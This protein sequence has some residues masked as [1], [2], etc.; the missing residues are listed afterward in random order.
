MI[1]IKNSKNMKRCC[2]VIP[3]HESVL[4]NAEKT[5]VNSIMKELEGYHVVFVGP[6]KI[7]KAFLEFEDKR[8]SYEFFDESFFHSIKSYNCLLLSA[9]FYKR[10]ISFEYILIA[11]TDCLIFSSNLDDWCNKEFSYIGAPWFKGFSKPSKPLCFYGVG[12]GGLSL[13]KVEDFLSV[14]T[15]KSY[16]KTNNNLIGYMILRAALLLSKFQYINIGEDRF[17]GLLA[18]KYSASFV[19][20]DP[21]EAA[22][23]SIEVEPQYLCNLIGHLPFGCHAWER[24]DKDYWTNHS[25]VIFK[26]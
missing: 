5:S 18:N 3:F 24:Y 21:I 12:N 14:F 19:V 6:R 17:W 11:Q 4:T 25:K 9:N 13:R 23:F 26:N 2:I 8:T 15:F 20:P 7:K 22:H 1:E 10:F 16:S